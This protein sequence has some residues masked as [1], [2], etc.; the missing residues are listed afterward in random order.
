MHY[1]NV[2]FFLS[3][4]RPLRLAPTYDMLPMMY[5]PDVEGRLPDRP[6]KPH[7][8]LPEAMDAW[9]RAIEMA[10]AY[11]GA[12]AEAAKVSEEFRGIAG[13][14]RETLVRHMREFR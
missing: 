10:V 4:D 1:G 12:V 13:R 7:P 6:F 14:N 3:R 8:P 11:W 2:S 9:S 5:R